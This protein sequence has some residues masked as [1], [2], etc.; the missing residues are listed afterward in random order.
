M[1]HNLRISLFKLEQDLKLKKWS[2]FAQMISRFFLE[3][4]GLFLP[5]FG[6]FEGT[7]PCVLAT[8]SYKQES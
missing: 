2:M 4:A 8:L 1:R 5:L 7:E 6:L 3:L